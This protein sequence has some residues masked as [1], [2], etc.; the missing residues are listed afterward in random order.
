MRSIG[1]NKIHSW[2][3]FDSIG[4]AGG[5]LKRWKDDLFEC[6][7]ELA[8]KFIISVRLCIRSTTTIFAVSSAY[9]PRANFERLKF[10]DEMKATAQWARAPWLIGGDFNITHFA[11]ERRDPVLHLTNMIKF[12]VLISDIFFY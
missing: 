9:G 4:A 5:Q 1:G 10:W 3:Y 6:I 12:N 8:E 7:S 2:T 11:G